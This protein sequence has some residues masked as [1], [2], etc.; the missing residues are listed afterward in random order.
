MKPTPSLTLKS[1]AAVAGLAMIADAS[2][3]LMPP[4]VQQG[5]TLYSPTRSLGDQK[6]RLRSWGSGLIAETDEAAFEGTSS[7]RI[8]SRN[9]FQGG[10][11]IYETPVNLTAAYDDKSNLLRLVYQPLGTVSNSGA[12][13]RNGSGGRPGADGPTGGGREPGG[14]GTPRPGGAPLGGLMGSQSGPGGRA[15]Q[16]GPG[17]PPGL[18]GSMGRGG[19]GQGAMG[20]AM[21]SEKPA[22]K[23]VRF[24]VTTTD[25]LRSE[26]YIPVATS[27][28]AQDGWRQVGIPLRAIR[29]FERTNKTIKEITVASDSTSAFYL[30]DLRVVS[31]PT[32]IRAEPSVRSLNVALN[33]IAT[34]S[35]QG[36]GGSSVLRYT[37]DFDE[38]DGISVDAEGASVT[39]KFRKP[40]TF[41]VTVTVQDEYGLKD[42][43][44][45]TIKVKVNG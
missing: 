5:A 13:G 8:T 25:N 45:T 30:G 18:G 7:L 9:F 10:T 33:D 31:D 2:A 22:L 39:H 27:I 29:G 44:S 6:I 21:S 19:P 3:F 15:P 17:G 40:G 36:E 24:V 23:N 11:L 12:G 35:A 43:Y 20:G 41:T 42:P 1:L 16:N 4:V 34:L 32:P 38:S 37:W 14:R 28:S 26:A